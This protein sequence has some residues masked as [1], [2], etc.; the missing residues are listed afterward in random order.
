VSRKFYRIDRKISSRVKET[1]YT[2]FLL[3]GPYLEVANPS[4][5]GKKST[6]QGS[7]GLKGESTLLPVPAP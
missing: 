2:S 4:R 6:P 7:I 3:V 1:V 5:K